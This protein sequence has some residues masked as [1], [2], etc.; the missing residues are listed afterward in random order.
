[1]MVSSHGRAPDAF[2]LSLVD[3]LGHVR[4]QS[5]GWQ[6]MLGYRPDQVDGCD[7]FSFLHADDA[8][9]V[10]E[11][12]QALVDAGAESGRWIVRFRAAGGG[13]LPLEVRARN[14][15]S[16]P[17]VRGILLSLRQVPMN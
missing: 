8:A 7:W 1:M 12:F 11:Q 9:A 2:T 14:L 16:D 17:D 5:S 10:R 3:G 15:L 6:S 4:Y 13:S